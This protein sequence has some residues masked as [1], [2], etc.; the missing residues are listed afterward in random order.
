MDLNVKV[1]QNKIRGAVKLSDGTK[2][3]IR[4]IVKAPAK[5]LYSFNISDLQHI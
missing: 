1:V 2:N 5:K 4:Y 3:A